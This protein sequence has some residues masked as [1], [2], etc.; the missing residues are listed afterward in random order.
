MVHHPA[1]P[2]PETASGDF[3]IAGDGTLVREQRRP[4]PEIAEIGEAFLSVRDAPDRSRNLV[5][6]PSE[7]KPMFDA[8]RQVIAGDVDAIAA[9]FSLAL[10]TDAPLWRVGLS[11]RQAGPGELDIVLVGCGASLRGLEIARE[12]GSTRK[13]ILG[14]P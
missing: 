6:I 8:L 9:G 14:R 13:I 12:G 3:R 11:P 10:V 2:K 5:P 7:M 1:L 4:R